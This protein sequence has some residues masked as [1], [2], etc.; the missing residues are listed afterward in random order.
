MIFKTL[1]SKIE[2]PSYEINIKNIDLAGEHWG[3]ENKI[4]TFLD[5]IEN[6]TFDKDT[7]NKNIILHSLKLLKNNVRIN[8][9]KFYRIPEENKIILLAITDVKKMKDF[10]LFSREMTISL[11]KEKF[12]FSIVEVLDEE[13]DLIKKG[14]K[15]IPDAWKLDEQLTNK[16]AKLKHYQF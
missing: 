15:S 14:E 9:V 6:F 8:D 4:I 12:V 11:K 2:K 7:F 1:N 3:S 16:F 5:T 10:E 13:Y